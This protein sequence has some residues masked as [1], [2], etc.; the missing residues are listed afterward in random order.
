MLS[1]SL[2]SDSDVQCLLEDTQMSSSLRSQQALV[3]VASRGAGARRSSPFRCPARRKRRESGSPS[4]LGKR[5]RF[6]SGSE[7]CS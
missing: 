5:V 1:S 4:R 7:L 3:E 2:F 6:D